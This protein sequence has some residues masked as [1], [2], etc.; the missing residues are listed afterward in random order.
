MIAILLVTLINAH[1][2]T[3]KMGKTGFKAGERLTSAST[4]MKQ[5]YREEDW[6]FE[7]ALGAVNAMPHEVMSML[8]QKGKTGK[9]GKFLESST[10][11]IQSDKKQ[12]VW[13][14]EELDRARIILNRMYDTEQA[15]LD[16][17]M[18]D[19]KKYLDGV[20]EQMDENSRIRLV[21]GE[22][23]AAARADQLESTKSKKEAETNL[24]GLKEEYEAH[25]ALCSSTLAAK[26]AEL[27]MAELDYNVAL[28][29]ENSSTCTDEQIQ[30][31]IAQD[32]SPP[33][34]LLQN[35]TDAALLAHKNQVI[36]SCHMSGGDDD[37]EDTEDNAFFLF[38]GMHDHP[39]FHTQAAKFAMQRMAKLALQRRL[40]KHSYSHKLPISLLEET[41]PPTTTTASDPLADMGKE[42]AAEAAPAEELA[43]GYKCNVNAVPNCPLLND[44]ISV[45]V[46]ELRDA[47]ITI[48]TDFEATKAHCE[49]LSA[50]YEAQIKDWQSIH[51]RA[52]VTLTKAITTIDT[53]QAE[54]A[55]K[56]KEYT[57]LESQWN[58]KNDE[59]ETKK[60]AILDTM[61]GIKVVRLEIF[62][63]AEQQ[64]M[65]QDCDVGDWVPQECSVSCAGGTQYLTR[66]V[67]A[68]PKGGAE[69]PALQMEQ[70]CNDF[71]CPINCQTDD[72]S[73][74]S[75]CSKDC[76]GGVM[77]RSRNIEIEP[78]FGGEECPPTSDAQMCNVGSCDV[79]CTIDDWSE[80]SPC[81]KACDGGIQVRRRAELTP[82]QGAG[83]C[84]D[85]DCFEKTEQCADIRFEQ[86][87]CN[88]MKCDNNVACNSKIDL[89]LLLD[90]SGSVRPKGFKKEK[91]FAEDLLSRMTI[92]EEGAKAGYILFSKK[93]E[94]GAEMSFDEATMLADIDA[95]KFPAR[96]TNTAEALSTALEVL[97][98]GGRKDA[99]SIVFVITDGMPNDVEA[100]AMM[101]EK[102]K[103]SARL[104]FVAV[105]SN[106]DM[107]Q[108]Y[109]W[110]SFPPEMNVLTAP[111]FKKLK[112]YVGEF[113]ADICPALK[114]D[115]TLE[116]NGADYIGCQSVTVS[117]KQCQKWT[118]KFP[119]KHKFVNKAKKARKKLGDNAFCRNPDGSET[120]WCYTTDPNTRWEACAPRAT[121]VYAPR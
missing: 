78:E 99:Q 105:G 41:T 48:K 31:A 65:F 23:T 68:E 34:A 53:N 117:G 25:Q 110:A 11:L 43:P 60:R 36:T 54:G 94:I 90:G 101:A 102:V 3:F 67:L 42:P 97:A 44:A 86:K 72:W 58:M 14:A 29:I 77:A 59:C 83:Y 116:G 9:H 107:D 2:H 13:T 57:E 32:E 51:D 103:Q 121:E 119:Q 85:P 95:E 91:K 10:E 80:W 35:A 37:D 114:C 16:V 82:L 26:R 24:E 55:A 75:S 73:G 63:M 61:C 4:L 71:P 70:A 109:S 92:S 33:P 45:M 50:D 98:A 49:A 8:R 7:R 111:K 46:S 17:L 18:F 64:E 84:S 27:T 39:Q 104:V 20:Q 113:M 79:D 40:G 66:E 30:A 74:W 81:S 89:L 120:I 88:D 87:P 22:E 15:E 56:A 38:G 19:C 108:L 5:Y 118:E 76:G 52:E 93:I 6:P 106:L 112:Q 28:K 115:E 62:K 100:T 96:T 1:D 69:C 12:V 47:F 21:L